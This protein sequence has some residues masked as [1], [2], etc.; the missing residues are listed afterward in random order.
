VAEKIAIDLGS[1]QKTLFMPLWG[2][3]VESEKMHPLLVDRTAVAIIEQV[4]YDFSTM[5]QNTSA[6]TQLAWIMRSIY[7]DEVVNT[8]LTKY[9]QGTIVNIGCGLDTTFDR[10]DNGR[11]VWYDLDLPDVISL[12]RKFIS[13]TERRHFIATSLFEEKW[14]K[15]IHI[16]GGVLFIVAGVIY[17]FTEELV[18]GLLIR[19][20]DG[21]PGGE[22]IFDVCS[23]FGMKVAN[24][25]VIQKSGLDERSYL[26]WGLSSTKA[27]LAWDSR[28]RILNTYYYFIGKKSLILPLKVRLIGMFFDVFKIQY[29]LHL[30]I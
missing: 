9:P 18:K 10:V 8:F 13:E 30:G 24:R 25:M 2:R 12:R 4:N 1:V 28:F 22:L 27:L 11:L 21:F 20:A 15:D 19:L 17:Y 5:G 14:L 29:M 26:H 6:V 3:A 7:V 16:N 23:P